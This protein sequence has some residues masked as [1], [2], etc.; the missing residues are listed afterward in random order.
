MSG[1]QRPTG[2]KRRFRTALVG[3]GRIS[4]VH[5]SA[6]RA[7]ADVVGV[8]DVDSRAACRVGAEHGIGGV[9]DDLD[10]MMSELAP[11]V[12]HLLTP[13]KTHAA[14]ADIVAK[15]GAHLYIEKP[16]ASEEDDARRIVT[17][18]ERA[19][20]TV[21]PGH[22]RLF[23]PL[24]LGAQRRVG[25]GEI[26]RVVSVRVEQGF[27]YE[28]AARGASV[29]WSYRYDWG[30]FDNLI[31][32]PLYLASRFLSAPGSPVVV[33]FNVGRTREA[34]VEEIRVLI[35]SRS[36]VGE[37]ALSLT[38]QPE[39]NRMEIVGTTGRITID[40]LGMYVLLNR[41]GTSNPLARFAEPFSTS[42]QLAAQASMNV[43]RIAT[44]RMKR[45][46]AIRNLISAFYASLQSGE[47]PPV[48]PEEGLL[49]VRQMQS[50]RLQCEAV[51]KARSKKSVAIQ[52]V[53]KPRIL[54]TGATGFVGGRLIDHFAVNAHAVR[55]TMRVVTRTRPLPGVEWVQCDLADEDQLR[56]AAAG[57]DTIF[58]CAALV[59]PPSS[60][61][62]YEET[63]RNGTVRLLEIAREAGVRCVVYVSS[64]GV[65]GAPKRGGNNII[66]LDESSPLEPRARD[67]GS[68]TQTKVAA[69]LAVQ[70]FA[71]TRDT[72]RIVIL[73]PGTIFGPGS[74]VPYGR[75]LLGQWRGRPLVV[76][77]RS[78]PMQ[79]TYIDN[80][81]DAMIAAA[82]ASLPSGRIYDVIDEP[83]V[84]QGRL[85]A[86]I[87]EV[88]SGRVRPILVPRSVAWVAMLAFDILSLIRSR[89]LG[90]A[91]Y[92]LHRTLAKMRFRTEAVR[93]ELKWA[94]TVSLTD[95]LRSVFDENGEPTYPH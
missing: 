80:L 24:F 46:Q 90:T 33:G 60:L 63:N 44:G 6:L 29:P 38:T 79:L 85:H 48:T 27:T 39:R 2:A 49:N 66:V 84:D 86:S 55:A 87:A 77:P 71:R 31:T 57:I 88:T 8:C 3:C 62:E 32:H 18:G 23:D 45:F 82:G 73:R 95:A 17:S 61:A 68:Y 50:I 7:V 20:I 14:L 72:P 67:R 83:D 16:L 76:G 42:A 74:P 89:R 36:A 78:T 93:N 34:A 9:Y 28:A 91:R 12:V 52:S 10:L 47:A 1:P 21:C 11:D 70:E 30:I 54:V 94:P 43:L 75:F 25:D 13:P 81:I 26:G 69:D 4:A 59:G 5:V 40:F 53:A 64:L 19:G 22:S 37:V 56:R 65:Y 41:G 51:V 15:Q 58:H 35:P 92:R